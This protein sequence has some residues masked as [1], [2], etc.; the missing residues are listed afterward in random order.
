MGGFLIPGSSINSLLS[1]PLISIALCVSNIGEMKRKSDSLKGKS[2]SYYLEGL[3]NSIRFLASAV[4]Y[5]NHLR[6]RI[7]R[8]HVS[9][10]TLAELCKWKCEVGRDSLF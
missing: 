10:S 4:N 2:E 9:D 5:I 3:N 6:K 7:V 1:K 8:L